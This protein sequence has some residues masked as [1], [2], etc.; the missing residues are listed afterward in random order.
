MNLIDNALQSIKER[1]LMKNSNAYRPSINVSSGSKGGD[2]LITI[3]DNGIGMDKETLERAF[4]PLFTTR[5]RG[6]GLGLANVEKIIEEHNGSILLESKPHK[7]TTV[8][9]AIPAVIQ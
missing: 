8:I 9:I 2:L 6:T 5:A 4:E 3:K 1:T 7:G